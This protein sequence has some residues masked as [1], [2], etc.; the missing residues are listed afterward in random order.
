VSRRARDILG[1]PLADFARPGFL[2]EHV[3]PD[4]R[5]RTRAVLAEAA[6]EMSDRSTTHRLLAADGS[7]PWFHTAVSCTAALENQH[8]EL[9]GLSIDVSELMVSEEHR[10]AH[11]LRGQ[12]E[13]VARDTARLREEL[14]HGRDP[15]TLTESA[16][17]IERA[18]ETMRRL[19]GP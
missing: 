19:V 5:D 17:R 1:Y 14:A 18:A 7:T 9:H 8:I 12:L 13:L 3:H 2:L 4:D 6:A 10:L 16:A 11:E 15:T